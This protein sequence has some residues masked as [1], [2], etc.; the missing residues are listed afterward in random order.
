MSAAALFLFNQ[1]RRRCHAFCGTPQRSPHARPLQPHPS[2]HQRC[3]QGYT[4]SADIDWAHYSRLPPRN[5]NTRTGIS[6]DKDDEETAGSFYWE[7]DDRRLWTRWMR[8]L[9]STGTRQFGNRPGQT[10]IVATLIVS[11]LYQ[12]ATTLA[13]MR[14]R[15][16]AEWGGHWFRIL[17]DVCMGTALPGPLLQLGGM[18]TAVAL[19]N[20]PLASSAAPFRRLDLHRYLLSG[21]LHGSALHWLLDVYLLASR[22]QIPAWLETGLGPSLFTTTFAASVLAGNAALSQFGPVHDR[23][24]NSLPPYLCGASGGICG[25]YGLLLVALIRMRGRGDGGGGVG[26]ALKGL[27]WTMMY[28]YFIPE[29]SLVGNL[30]GLVGGAIVGV[31]FGPRYATSYGMKRKWSTEVDAYSRDYRRAMGF[32]IQPRPPLLPLTYLWAFVALL[33][34]LVPPLR[35]APLAAWQAVTLRP[36]RAT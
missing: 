13:W 9:R 5:R 20:A 10:A 14:A 31:M 18:R 1:K 30:G 15:F 4:S 25:L 27:M 23:L 33:F 2:Q 36:S 17:V 28:G 24:A 19:T 26:R 12:L 34:A 8:Q 32:G 11:Y 3:Y 29:V 35:S 21:I 7:G 22:R 6:P 16:P